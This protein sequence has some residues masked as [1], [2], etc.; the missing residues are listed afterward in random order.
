MTT[1]RMRRSSLRS[2]GGFT[3]IEVLA[4]SSIIAVLIASLYAAM[5]VAFAARDTAINSIATT[6]RLNT[7]VELLRAD[8]Q[9]AVVP[10]AAWVNAPLNTLAG[11]FQGQ[12]SDNE[13]TSA[14][15]NDV[16]AFYSTVSDSDPA[17]GV[18]EIKRIE[19]T[20]E[21]AGDTGETCLVRRVTSNLLS[22]DMPATTAEII[23]RR[24]LSFTLEYFDGSS[25]QSSWDS[26]AMSNA[27][28]QAVLITLELQDDSTPAGDTGPQVTRVVN[29]PCAPAPTPNPGMGGLGGL[30]S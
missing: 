4:A 9:S 25:W 11:P 28:P 23:C 19:Y 8:L 22:T 2:S 3:L 5:Q 27:L 1:K 18:G 29:L 21:P 26:T 24:V 13:L 7:A 20:I 16:L 10:N 6:R 17:I 15:G 12:S 14:I 30:G